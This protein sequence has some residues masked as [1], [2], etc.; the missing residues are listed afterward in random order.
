MECCTILLI[1]HLSIAYINN[2]GGDNL[3]L[4]QFFKIAFY[5]LKLQHLSRPA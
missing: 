3:L 5:S 1:E 2:A 4:T